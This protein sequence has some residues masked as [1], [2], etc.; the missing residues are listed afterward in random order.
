MEWIIWLTAGTVVGSYE[1]GKECAGS[2]K[3]GEFLTS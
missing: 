1:N 3:F 2:I